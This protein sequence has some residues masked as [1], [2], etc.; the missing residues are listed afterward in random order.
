[1][2]LL[3]PSAHG[4]YLTCLAVSVYLCFIQKPVERAGCLPHSAISEVD[5]AM[6]AVKVWPQLECVCHCVTQ[7]MIQAALQFYIF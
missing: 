2:Y 5:C 4:I 7:A 6:L 3:P 1:M